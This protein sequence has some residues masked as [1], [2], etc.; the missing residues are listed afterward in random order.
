[1]AISLRKVA[2]SALLVLSGLM[3]TTSSA[4]FPFSGSAFSR[5][6][7]KAIAELERKLD[8]DGL[9]E[10]AGMRLKSK[11]NDAAWLYVD[12][13]ALQQL[14]R[15]HEAI[16]RFRLILLV[17]TESNEAQNELARCLL[18]TGQLDAAKSTLISLSGNSPG[19]WQA[20]YNLVLVYVRQQDLRGARI[21]LEKLKSIN[22]KMA[23]EIEENEVNPLE[24]RLE[25]EGI[26]EANRKQEE[27]ARF[28]RERVARE[29]GLLER[30]VDE[31]R[32]K[33]VAQ[34][35]VVE[36]KLLPPDPPQAAAVPPKSHEVKLK[37]LKRLYA[38][39]MITQDVYK[40][41]QKE[42]LAQQ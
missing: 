13:F 7:K 22:R 31:A 23:I 27:K 19:Y 34:A 4:F 40:A 33:A 26:A 8:W 10:L 25:Q 16:P 21:H 15:C 5:G 3:P 14:G 28:E 20:Y 17:K 41:R 38:R 11:G 18:T 2:I 32:A 12:G 29:R 42:L 39:K 9:R 30:E 36:A 35:A 1:M 6:D 24:S 37:E